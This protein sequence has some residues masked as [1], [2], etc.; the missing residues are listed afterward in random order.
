MAD[1][2]DSPTPE[3][4]PEAIPMPPPIMSA[5]LP[6]AN[7]K[8]F[9]A[10]WLV[11]GGVIAAGI[12]FGTSRLVP[13]GWPLADT[14]AATSGLQAQVQQLAAD[15]SALKT[16]LND[17]AEHPALDPALNV[18]IVALE[19]RP[20]G[21]DQSADLM[22]LKAQV[23]ALSTAP[24]SLAPGVDA[25]AL[26]ALQDQVTA[27]SIAPSAAIDAAVKA[28][29]DQLAATMATAQASAAKLTTDAALTRIA[30][31]LE[32][33][34]PYAS[35]LTDLGQQTLPPV[36]L[37]HATSGLPTLQSLRDAF[38]KAARASLE[39]ARQADMGASWTDRISAFLQTQTGARS[40]T[41]REGNDP[42]AILSRA[43]AALA[44]GDLTATLAELAALPEA[45]K[46][47]LTGWTAQ[48]QLRLDA[49]T[50]LTDLAKAGG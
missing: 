20:A 29:Q 46:P 26:K 6:P 16:R 24:A 28:A 32:S 48:A 41:P 9:G 3:A 43:E 5:D 2:Q 34:A 23:Q 1:P 31:A 12:G 4:I 45:A 14:A 13:G 27:L 39:G 21:V 19:A 36:L 47:A 42:D 10:V 22:V 30:A 49:A 38:P 40:L 15:N 37:E 18:R 44:S 33:G 11:L 8:T 7:R 17:L 35:A 25:A 50:A